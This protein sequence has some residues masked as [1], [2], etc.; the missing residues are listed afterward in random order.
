M[1]VTVVQRPLVIK[2]VSASKVSRDD[3]VGS[4]SKFLNSEAGV[5][6]ASTSTIQQLMDLQ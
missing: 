3:A 1:P 5:Q 4:I 6:S 2:E